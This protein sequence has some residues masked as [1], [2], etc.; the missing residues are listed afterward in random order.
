MANLIKH[1]ALI[2]NDPWHAL[3]EDNSITDYA[4]VS[5]SRWQMERETLSALAHQGLLGLRL[6]SHETADLVA[7]D[8]HHF[9]LIAIDF[10]VFTDGRG[11]ST[12]RLLRE[13]YCFKGEL[14]A[15]G[16]ILIDQIHLLNRIGFDSLRLREDQN[17]ERALTAFKPF[18]FAYQSDVQNKRPLWRHREAAI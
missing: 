2:T 12:A 6:E 17:I 3:E 14:R 4:V 9:A 8:I 11:Y 10:P 1:Q 15:V 13:R 7:D 5:W 16:D 18:S